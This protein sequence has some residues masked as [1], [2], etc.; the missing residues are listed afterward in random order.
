V[1]DFHAGSFKCAVK[2]K[3]SIVPIA[4]IDTH[5]V[6]DG[7]GSKPITVQLHYLKPIPY[8]EYEGMSTVE[9]AKMVRERIGQV[10]GEKVC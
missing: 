3:C 7:K 10:I 6:L 5:K 9:I 4:L 1:F 8:E 2:A